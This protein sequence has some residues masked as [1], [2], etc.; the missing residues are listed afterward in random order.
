M[1]RFNSSGFTLIEMIIVIALMAG[2]IAV[3]LPKMNSFNKEQ[4]LP[5]A[6]DALQEAIRVAQSNA[7]SGVKCSSEASTAWYFE[8]K[9]NPGPSPYSYVIG[10]TCS[11]LTPTPLPSPISSS[12]NVVLV[13]IDGCSPVPS[14][15]SGMGVKFQN[16][17]GEVSFNQGLSGA[18]IVNQT[19]DQLANAKKMTITLQLGS[20]ASKQA[21]I[22]VEKGGAVYVSS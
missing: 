6:A 21:K 16:I 10:S 15:F 12:V 3:A 13:D 7:T 19:D 4:F 17:S 22:V 2:F 11:S 18:C 1:Q 5:Q 9:S 8:F 14:N 20:D